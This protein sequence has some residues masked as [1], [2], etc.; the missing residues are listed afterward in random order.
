VRAVERIRIRRR[1]RVDWR[2]LDE[3]SFRVA[4]NEV[5]RLENDPLH[6]DRGSL[7]IV[8]RGGA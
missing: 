8:T 2:E 3:L 6:P 1:G 7:T 5:L 4:S